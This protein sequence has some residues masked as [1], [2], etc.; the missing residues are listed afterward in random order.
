MWRCCTT[1]PPTLSTFFGNSTCPWKSH[2]WG[3]TAASIKSVIWIGMTS[4]RGIF[5]SNSS[6]WPVTIGT[7]LLELMGATFLFK[8]WRLVNAMVSAARCSH[9]LSWT[10]TCFSIVI[11]L[12]L[13]LSR[14]TINKVEATV[15]K[16]A[17]HQLLWKVFRS[18]P[19]WILIILATSQVPSYTL[20]IA[21]LLWVRNP[22]DRIMAKLGLSEQKDE[23]VCQNASVCTVQ[24][25]DDTD[26]RRSHTISRQYL[27]GQDFSFVSRS[28]R[29]PR[30][31]FGHFDRATIS[32][33]DERIPEFLIQQSINQHSSYRILPSVT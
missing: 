32:P 23:N 19:V 21:A 12:H 2:S 3:S 17:H 22:V 4:L 24:R 14:N 27:V 5:F 33:G 26:L 6:S 1:T 15:L 10:A 28:I 7:L 30:K 31:T 29:C 8:P 25:A 20:D 9:L 11:G 16:L 18:S 13:V